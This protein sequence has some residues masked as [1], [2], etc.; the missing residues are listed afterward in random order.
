AHGCLPAT[1]KQVSDHAVGIRLSCGNSASL[2]RA[3]YSRGADRGSSADAS[4]AN[5]GHGLGRGWDGSI[6]G[7][8]VSGWPR[9]LLSARRPAPAPHLPRVPGPS[10]RLLLPAP[11]RVLAVVRLGELTRG[12]LLPPDLLPGPLWMQ[13]EVLVPLLEV[14]ID[15]PPGL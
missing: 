9:S 2:S 13:P 7:L 3:E 15:G 1:G 10:L 11:P 6:A 5:Q 4:V 8:R 12:R 14:P